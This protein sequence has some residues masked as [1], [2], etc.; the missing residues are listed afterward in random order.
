MVATGNRSI[1]QIEREMDIS[2]RLIYKWQ[3]RYKVKDDTLPTS[4]LVAMI[5]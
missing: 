4:R 1:A 3:Q 5:S 2:P